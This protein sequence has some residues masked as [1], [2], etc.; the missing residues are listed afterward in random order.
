MSTAPA[1]RRLPEQQLL[2]HR[3]LALVIPALDLVVPVELALLAASA[4]QAV[5]GLAQVQ[6]AHPPLHSSLSN[7]NGLALSEAILRSNS[8]RRNAKRRIL[9]AKRGTATAGALRVRVLKLEA[10]CFQG[11]HVIHHAAI[12]IHQRSRID[13][14]LEAVEGENLVHHP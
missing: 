13:K 4:V 6:A 7:E 1:A 11:F 12:E 5:S 14:H 3:V 10:C 2:A 8:E 9:D